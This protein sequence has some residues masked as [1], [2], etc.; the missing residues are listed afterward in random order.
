MHNLRLA[1]VVQSFAR[2][3][4]RLAHSFR[5]GVIE[6]AAGQKWNNRRHVRTLL[7]ALIVIIF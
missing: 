3:V 7:R 4:E 2:G 5:C 1:G 6:N